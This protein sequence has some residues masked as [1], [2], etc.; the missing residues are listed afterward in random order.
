MKC[1]QDGALEIQKKLSYMVST[2]CLIINISKLRKQ[3]IQI[4]TIYKASSQFQFLPQNSLYLRHVYLSELFAL[5]SLPDYWMQ[6]SSMM[7]SERAPDWQWSACGC[8][9]SAVS[10]ICVNQS[11]VTC[12]QHW[13][14]GGGCCPSTSWCLDTT[15][16]GTIVLSFN[17]RTQAAVQ[18][19]FALKY[20]LFV[21][22]QLDGS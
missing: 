5:S 18:G 16:P 22:L 2:Y 14:C 19:R 11:E 3:N 15:Q 20:L 10:I 17:H 8:N 4:I 1:I 13:S 21:L 7:T 6:S 9:Q 12:G